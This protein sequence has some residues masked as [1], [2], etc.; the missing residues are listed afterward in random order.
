LLVVLINPVKRSII[1][2]SII[3]ETY[4]NKFLDNKGCLSF[5]ILALPSYDFNFKKDVSKP[6]VCLTILA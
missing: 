1:Y 4:N 3:I 2:S 5:I 6:I